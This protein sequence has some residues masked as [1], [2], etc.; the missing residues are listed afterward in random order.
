VLGPVSCAELSTSAFH[1]HTHTR[2]HAYTHAFWPV[3]RSSSCCCWQHLLIILALPS[4]FLHFTMQRRVSVCVA[5]LSLTHT[6]THTGTWHKVAQSFLC[7]HCFFLCS[8]VLPFFAFLLSHTHTDTC[9]RQNWLWND[10]LASKTASILIKVTVSPSRFSSLF[11]AFPLFSCPSFFYPFVAIS[12]AR[13]T[14]R[15]MR[16][17]CHG[18]LLPPFFLRPSV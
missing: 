7:F 15:R 3:S 17:V 4:F 14:M 2:T 16:N 1:L 13:R 12:E 18:I 10:L 6:G 9:Q 8:L 5:C 11:L